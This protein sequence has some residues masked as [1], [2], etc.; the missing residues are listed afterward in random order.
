MIK[1]QQQ[2]LDE[3]TK[4]ISISIFSYSMSLSDN[5]QSASRFRNSID[6]TGILDYN[7]VGEGISCISCSFIP[8]PDAENQ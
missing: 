8:V 3:R 5:P 4:I 6:T 7:K 1:N 2:K